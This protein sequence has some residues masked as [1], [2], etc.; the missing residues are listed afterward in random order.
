MGIGAIA[1]AAI[2]TWVSHH[3]RAYRIQ[4]DVTHAGQQINLILCQA[5]AKPPLPQRTAASVGA[6]HVLHMA[7]PQRLH[8]PARAI[9]LMR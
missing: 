5:R 9:G 8:Q 2:F 7:L 3:P 6:I 1:R 4:F